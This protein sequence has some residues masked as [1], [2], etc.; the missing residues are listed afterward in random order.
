MM[1]YPR[2]PSLSR[3]QPARSAP[4]APWRLSS[5]RTQYMPAFA[6]CYIQVA[7]L[8]V[9]DVLDG[10][11]CA[12]CSTRS[13]LCWRETWPHGG[14][15]TSWSKADQLHAR[16]MLWLSYNFNADLRAKVCTS[17]AAQVRNRPESFKA[18]SEF[19]AQPNISL[20]RQCLRATHSRAAPTTS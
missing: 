8:R 18:F 10:A 20:R 7:Y 9:G 15:G 16:H 2:A 5:A 4:P 17:L 1:I 12:S 6:F 13:M 14:C 19:F 11:R 3:P